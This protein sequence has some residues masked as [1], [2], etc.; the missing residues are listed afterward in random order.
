MRLAARLAVRHALTPV[1]PGD[2]TGR[3]GLGV[4]RLVAVTAADNDA[5]NRILERAG[6]TVWGARAPPRRRTPASGPALHWEVLASE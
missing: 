4:R 3:S 5:S 2:L 6:F 1:A